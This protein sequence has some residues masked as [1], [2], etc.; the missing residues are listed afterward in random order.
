MKTLSILLVIACVAIIVECSTNQRQAM[1]PGSHP[2]NP[3]QCDANDPKL[4]LKQKLSRYET[5][6]KAPLTFSW[7]NCGSS[8]DPVLL[9]S[10]TLAPDPLVLGE[11]ITIGF[12]AS[13]AENISSVRAE[14]TLEKKILG[15][16]TEIPCIENV[17]SCSYDD[18]C[19]V[20]PKHPCGPILTKYHIPCHCPFPEGSYA[21]PPVS[22]KTKNP[23]LDW[24]TD[25][26]FYGMGQLYDSND[27]EIAC[28]EVYVSI[29][30]EK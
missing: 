1:K 8:S 27:N 19:D 16:W 5:K 23:N 9:K 13:L 21:L 12:S 24:L 30:T 25:G 14:V 15:I 18:L 7:D 17:G 3:A 4:N 6:P 2:R 11:N 20:L 29:S 10:L 22:V 28:Y 26:D